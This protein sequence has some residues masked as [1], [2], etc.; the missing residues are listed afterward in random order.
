DMIQ[1]DG[2]WWIIAVGLGTYMT[3]VP[4]STVLFDRLIA[5]TRSAGTAVF[6]IYLADTVGWSGAIAVP[7][8]KAL[9]FPEV[10]HF[11]FFC[12]FTYGL[13]GLGTVLL[14]GSCLYFL[15]KIQPQPEK[16]R[17]LSAAG[18]RG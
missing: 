18:E 6:T 14:V 2:L 3:Y 11:A 5:S 8:F 1:G 10:P 16:E 9:V 4:Y 7:I 12:W 17:I 13:S 15:R